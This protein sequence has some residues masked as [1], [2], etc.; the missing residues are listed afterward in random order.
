ML[1]SCSSWSGVEEMFVFMKNSVWR[2]GCASVNFAVTLP[3]SSEVMVESRQCGGSLLNA[4]KRWWG[5]SSLT[6]RS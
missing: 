3:V 6:K 1:L 2:R 5:T 4:E